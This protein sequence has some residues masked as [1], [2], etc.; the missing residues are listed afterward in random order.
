MNLISNAVYGSCAIHDDYIDIT[1]NTLINEVTKY[2]EILYNIYTY[3][4]HVHILIIPNKETFYMSFFNILLLSSTTD[5]ST[6]GCI[7]RMTIG[8]NTFIQSVSSE[9][10]SRY[11]IVLK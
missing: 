10:L 6:G 2:S 11:V 1:N 8:T 4:H 7:F 3:I 9:Q 5:V